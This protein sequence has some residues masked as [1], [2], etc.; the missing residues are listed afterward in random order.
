MRCFD[1]RSISVD[2]KQPG[3]LVTFEAIAG[4]VG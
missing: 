3:D 2:G 4:A 1:P